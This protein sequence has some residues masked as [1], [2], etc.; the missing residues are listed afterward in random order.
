MLL[1]PFGRNSWIMKSILFCEQLLRFSFTAD[2]EP[3]R[4]PRHQRLQRIKQALPPLY[5]SSSVSPISTL[6]TASFQTRGLLPS[7]LF[8]FP[9]S[10]PMLLSH[11]FNSPLLQMGEFRGRRCRILTNPI[12]GTMVLERDFEQILQTDQKEKSTGGNKGLSLFLKSGFFNKRL[13]Q[14]WKQDTRVQN[15]PGLSGLRTPIKS[16][17]H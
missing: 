5:T 12:P 7:A 17:T 6:S 9:S 3:K 4:F 14:R 1:W 2:L 11:S 13:R 15:P 8:S 16:R 10:C